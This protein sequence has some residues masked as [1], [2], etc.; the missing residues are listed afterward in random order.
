METSTFRYTELDFVYQIPP[1]SHQQRPQLSKFDRE[2]C[3]RWDEAMAAGVFRYRI[4]HILT[5]TIPG[6]RQYLAQLNT[7]RATEKRKGQEFTKVSQPFNDAVFNFSWV[8]PE[9]V[10]FNL[11][12]RSFSGEEIL[13]SGDCQREATTE[14]HTLIVNVSPVEYGHCLLV[15]EIDSHRPQV[16]TETSLRVAIETMLLSQHRG[17]RMGFNSLCGLASVN[18]LH[19]HLYYLDHKLLVENIPVLP[20]AGRYFELADHPCPGFALQLHGSTLDDLAR[21]TYAIS[22]HLNQNDIAHNLFMTRGSVFG[23]EDNNTQTTIRLF[24]WP[25]KKFT[26]SETTST[27]LVP[28]EEFNVACIELPGHLAV[29]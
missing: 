23:E 1:R 21:E 18:H 15:P 6:R 9:E 14:R 2:L 28:P 26:S 17:L 12:N 13:R 11:E 4:D 27:D 24:I 22:S 5:R 10:I 25:R 3:K 7:L 29:K 8:G 20:L 16:L 19:F